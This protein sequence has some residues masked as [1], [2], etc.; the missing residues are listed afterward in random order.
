M[1]SASAQLTSLGEIDAA[2]SLQQQQMQFDV[3]KVQFDEAA[4]LRRLGRYDAQTNATLA[5][6][7]ENVIRN[8]ETT[9]ATLLQTLTATPQESRQP[10]QDAINAIDL[11]LGAIKARFNELTGV[12][13]API[14]PPNTTT[15][16]NN[17]FIVSPDIQRDLDQY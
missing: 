4:E 13:A 5:G 17:D 14:E 1:Q 11:E 7:F 12:R 6:T 16:A 9:K 10:I 3:I 15:G 8:A 2:R